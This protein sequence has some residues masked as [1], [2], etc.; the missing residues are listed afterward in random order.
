MRPAVF[1]A[2]RF[3]SA[4]EGMKLFPKDRVDHADVRQM[5]GQC[6][7]TLRGAWQSEF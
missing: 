4:G 7:V 2:G 1:A 3:H 5:A 6:T